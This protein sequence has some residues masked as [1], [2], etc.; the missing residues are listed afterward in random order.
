MEQIA[1]PVRWCAG[2]SFATYLFHYPLLHLSAAF[3]PPNQGWLAIGITLAI[4]AVLGPLAE[5]SKSLWR[6]GLNE[7]VNLALGMYPRKTVREG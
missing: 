2:V 1:V 6:R 7:A 3:L 4:I 5:R